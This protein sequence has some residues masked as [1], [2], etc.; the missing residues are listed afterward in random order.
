LVGYTNAGKTTL[1]NGLTDAGLSAKNMPFETLD[2]TSRCL[3]RHGGDVLLSDTVGFIRRLPDRLLASF[4]STLAEARE[5]SLLALVVDAADPEWRFHLD[6]TE[7]LLT[8]LGADAIPRFFVF[9]KMD[10]VL[11]APWEAEL[12][13]RARGHQFMA[14]S[15]HDAESVARLRDALIRSVRRTQRT[16]TLFVPYEASDVMAA[17]YAKCRIVTSEASERGLHFTLEGEEHVVERLER[18][19]EEIQS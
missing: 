2:T 5:A 7:E 12:A 16:A 1:M 11:S 18:E 17:V 6:T 3:T 15:G 14:L 8:R 19:T 13:A 10:R 9:N 4:E